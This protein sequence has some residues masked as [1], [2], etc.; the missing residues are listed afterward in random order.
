MAAT[1]RD[2]VETRGKVKM[3]DAESAMASVVAA[4][5]DLVDSGDIALVSDDEDDT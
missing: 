3:K 2:E 4:L 1:L 5:R